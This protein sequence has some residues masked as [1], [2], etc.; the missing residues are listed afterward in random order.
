MDLCDVSRARAGR[1][2]RRSA[3]R[4]TPRRRVRRPHRV[5]TRVD[6]AWAT[7]ADPSRAPPWPHKST[8]ARVLHPQSDAGFPQSRPRKATPPGCQPPTRAVWV[9]AL[10]I[11]TE[12]SNARLVSG[13]HDRFLTTERESDRSPTCK[14]DP[15]MAV[16][17]GC[18]GVVLADGLPKKGIRRGAVRHRV[19]LSSVDQANRSA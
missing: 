16:R 17:R 12:R 4:A 11:N 15:T 19:S 1:L 14:R 7:T 10:R 9:P 8:R 3:R 5:G 18:G 6:R 13:I 2:P